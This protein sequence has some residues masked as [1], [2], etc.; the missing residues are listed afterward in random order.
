MRDI[1]L[2]SWSLRVHNGAITQLSIW[3]S[4]VFDIFVLL[5]AVL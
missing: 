4:M 1:E 5:K 2:V 3:Q